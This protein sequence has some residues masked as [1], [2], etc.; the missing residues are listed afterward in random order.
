MALTV[1]S[2]VWIF[3]YSSTYLCTACLT[4]ILET[5]V[6]C[7]SFIPLSSRIN[8]MT[9]AFVLIQVTECLKNP[10]LNNYLS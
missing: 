9:I 3:R 4:R 7:S 5:R 6:D 8:L 1:I 10:M 2:M